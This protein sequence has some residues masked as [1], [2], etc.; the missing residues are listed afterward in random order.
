MVILFPATMP[1]Q[2]LDVLNY[3]CIYQ[4]TEGVLMLFIFL[5]KRVWESS[6][7][8]YPSL[9]IFTDHQRSMKLHYLTGTFSGDKLRNFKSIRG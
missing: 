2:I 3:E 1:K 6:S 5:S 8:D 9:F 7:S 4:L